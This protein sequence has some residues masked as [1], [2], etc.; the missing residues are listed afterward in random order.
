MRTVAWLDCRYASYDWRGL[1][2]LAGLRA[3][4]ARSVQ[5]LLPHSWDRRARAAAAHVPTR[6]QLPPS[7]AAPA[8]A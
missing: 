8:H 3:K 6:R 4:A 7:L 1:S 5:Q 2:E